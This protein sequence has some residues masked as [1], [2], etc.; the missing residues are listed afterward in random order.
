MGNLCCAREHSVQFFLQFFYTIKLRSL[1]VQF[2]LDC[3]GPFR[4]TYLSTFNRFH[5]GL[6]VTFSVTD[7][8]FRQPYIVRYKCNTALVCKY[9]HRLSNINRYWDVTSDRM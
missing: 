2:N 3:M 7:F 1:T 5:L 6:I 4:T 8:F 9:F